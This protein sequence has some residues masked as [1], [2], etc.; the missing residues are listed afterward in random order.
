MKYETR[1]SKFEILNSKNMKWKIVSH[2]KFEIG[3]NWINWRSCYWKPKWDLHNDNF[4]KIENG[5]EFK[6]IN[7]WSY[8]VPTT[9][10]LFFLKFIF[11]IKIKPKLISGDPRYPQRYVEFEQTHLHLMDIPHGSWADK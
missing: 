2:E 1:N 9:I 6:F 8:F 4:H 7:S 10:K 3:I 11:Y 5:R